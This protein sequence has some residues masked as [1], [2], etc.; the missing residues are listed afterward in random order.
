MPGQP[1]TGTAEY[2]PCRLRPQHD[3]ACRLPVPGG[4]GPHQG[5]DQHLCIII[6][7]RLR[8]GLPAVGRWMSG[9]PRTQAPNRLVR[10]SLV[11][12]AQTPARPDRATA[13]GGLDWPVTTG[14]RWRSRIGQEGTVRARP[15]RIGGAYDF[16][17]AP[18]S[19]VPPL[20]CF[21]ARLAAVTG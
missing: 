11:A 16:L 3:A 8:T 21:F 12:A 2:P 6:V 1:A 13:G 14:H 10:C 20:C 4:A 15:K 9:L 19:D 17:P 18:Q 7:N 5:Q